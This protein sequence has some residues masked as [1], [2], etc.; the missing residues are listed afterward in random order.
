MSWVGWQAHRVMGDI[1]AMVQLKQAQTLTHA[2]AQTSLYWYGMTKVQTNSLYIQ[3]FSNHLNPMIHFFKG[4]GS[5]SLKI[6]FQITRTRNLLYTDLMSIKQQ[7]RF[8]LSSNNHIPIGMNYT[9]SNWSTY[10][11]IVLFL[12]ITYI[13]LGCIISLEN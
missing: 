2:T 4:V 6:H 1:W 7:Y 13:L 11:E 3:W 5:V 8:I 10:V 12:G 9:S